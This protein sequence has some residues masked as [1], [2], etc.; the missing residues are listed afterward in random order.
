MLSEVYAHSF[1]AVSGQKRDQAWILLLQLV[2][3]I[4]ER[5]PHCVLYH[6]FLCLFHLLESPVQVVVHLSKERGSLLID[7]LSDGSHS[8]FIEIH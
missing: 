2:C 1:E 6:L 8:I 7:L 3:Y 4:L 5:F